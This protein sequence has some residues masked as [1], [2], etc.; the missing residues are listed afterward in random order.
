MMD[1]TEDDDCMAFRKDENDLMICVE[2]GTAR[3]DDPCLKCEQHSYHTK[4]C[5]NYD[6][7]DNRVFMCQTY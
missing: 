1:H 5:P 3:L 7:D 4:E 6:S 2:C